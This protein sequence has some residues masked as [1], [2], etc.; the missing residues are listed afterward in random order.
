M[1]N[2]GFTGRDQAEV[3]H[4]LDELSAKGIPVPDETP[5]I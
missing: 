4:H 5:L 3:R 1:V 2:A